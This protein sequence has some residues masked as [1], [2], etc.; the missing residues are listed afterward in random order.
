LIIA[1]KRRQSQSFLYTSASSYIAL[2]S[3]NGLSHS[4]YVPCTN[5][6][7]C[8]DFDIAHY[9]LPRIGSL[10]HSLFFCIELSLLLLIGLL[11]LCDLTLSLFLPALKLF[12]TLLL[13]CLSLFLFFFLE[14]IELS[15]FLLFSQFC[16]HN[17]FSF[18][19]IKIV[20]SVQTRHRKLT[21]RYET[22]W[23]RCKLLSLA[24]HL[25]REISKANTI[26]GR[27]MLAL[28][29]HLSVAI[30]LLL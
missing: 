2:S 14:K 18:F 25:N 27:L 13:S 10:L 5:I 20:I 28:P 22:S 7:S 12:S 4:S 6:I 9:S 23:N 19:R 15:H 17:S 21:L 16:C 29:L 11:S 26:I 8:I 30:E 24:V 3:Y 1:Y